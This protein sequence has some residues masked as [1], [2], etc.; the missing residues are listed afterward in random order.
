MP[1]HELVAAFSF[2]HDVAMIEAG[3]LRPFVELERAQQL[4][5]RDCRPK[6]PIDEI[7][8]KLRAAGWRVRNGGWPA[9]CAAVLPDEGHAFPHDGGG[10]SRSI[11]SACL[12]TDLSTLWLPMAADKGQFR[13]WTRLRNREGGHGTDQC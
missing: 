6:N 12:R 3:I 5:A 9:T 13:P 1:D 7:V 2:A 4:L 10:G 8:R 11:P